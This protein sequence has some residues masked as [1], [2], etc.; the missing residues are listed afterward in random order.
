VSENS[1]PFFVVPRQTDVLS[2]AA[3]GCTERELALQLGIAFATVRGHL[4]LARAFLGIRR[5]VAVAVAVGFV[6]VPRPFDTC[7][8]HCGGSRT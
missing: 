2:L 4:A 1:R 5:V 8:L 6:E 3:A 7:T